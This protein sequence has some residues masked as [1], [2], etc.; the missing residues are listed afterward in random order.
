[1]ISSEELHFNYGGA[2]SDR[3]QIETNCRFKIAATVGKPGAYF[4]FPWIET[5][6]NENLRVTLAKHAPVDE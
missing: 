6:R 2:A 1:M 4:Q 3:L 5:R